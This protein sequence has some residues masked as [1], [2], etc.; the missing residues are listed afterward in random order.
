MKSVIKPK[1]KPIAISMLLILS[2][3]LSAQET[4]QKLQPIEVK[5]SIGGGYAKKSAGL[6]P[7][8]DEVVRTEQIGQA[9]IAAS[10]AVSI[11]EA[12]EHKVGIDTQNECSIC[13]ARNISLNNIPGRFTTIM[14]DGI[15]LF[16]S[17]SSVYG[18]EGIPVNAL[19]RIEVA[20]GSAMSLV[21]PEAIAGSVNLV[22]K[23]ITKNEGMIRGEVGDI[24][25]KKIT[26]YQA[27]AGKQKG[28]Y[29]SVNG[30]Y[31]G[32]DAFDGDGNGVSESAAIE[33]KIGG[34]GIGL[35]HIAGWE[36]RV[37]LDYA[38]EKRTGGTGTH[39]TNFTNIIENN[40]GNPFNW[41]K[42]PNAS[43][44][45][46]G[47][48]NPTTGD[49]IDYKDGLVGMS[50]LID[51]KRL[52]GTFISE[53]KQG[54]DHYR[55]AAGLANHKQDSFYEGDFYKSNQDQ[56]YL[57][58]RWKHNFKDSALTGGIAYKEELHRSRSRNA[59]GID[60][61]GLDNY[62][63]RTPGVFAQYD[64]YGMGGDL[65]VNIS[66]RYDDH[67]V[68]GS[69]FIP[70]LLMAYSHTHELTSRFAVGQGYRAPTTFFEQDHGILTTTRIVRDPNLKA[71]KADNIAYNLTWDNDRT[72][73]STGLSW[74]KISNMATID[75]DATDTNG[76]AITFMGNA[77]SP[78]YL[79][80]LDASVSH[81][82][83][84][85]LSL[86][87]GVEYTSYDFKQNEA[88]FA[89]ARPEFRAF[90]GSDWEIGKFNWRN[91]ATYVG[92][93]DLSRFGNYQN[94]PDNQR[95]NLDGSPKLNKSPSFWKIDT[96][97]GYAI[98][99]T[100]NV[101]AG[102]NNLLDERQSKTE[103][104]L[105]LDSAGEID[106]THI[107]GLALG[108]NVFIGTEYKF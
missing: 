16:S 87:A 63:F 35:G 73:I 92:S 78:V 102:V 21:A 49:K 3:E 8:H 15:P 12:T 97:L 37:R 52:A 107:W 28:Q 59:D 68:Y 55:F 67:N 82:L 75:A 100:W 26:Y 105:W 101:Y 106:V 13:N 32:L 10:G 72:T 56:M 104:P 64:F 50:E 60:T 61:S 51:S 65:E 77:A 88:P 69:I 62:S 83:T 99:K 94:N 41:S 2:G 31:R 19:E 22:T 40:S 95:Y 66:G 57:E 45:A 11:T 4:T 96:R 20:R 36:T 30:Q 85:N 90:L 1:L 18:L 17:A 86:S 91:R 84:P 14:I 47:W 29:L 70:R 42:G 43:T 93:M 38:D 98:D 34:I 27:W 9:E 48:I 46:G 79:T 39:S 89:F 33:Q 103:S 71:E 81:T 58:G 25:D 53:R 44:Y 6:P 23:K 108:R 74:T 5:S 76:N 80:T 24:G 7:I 54:A